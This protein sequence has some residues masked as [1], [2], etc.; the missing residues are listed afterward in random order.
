MQGLSQILASAPLP[1]LHRL[2]HF[3]MLRRSQEL[4][5]QLFQLCDGLLLGVVFWLAHA[6]RFWGTVYFDFIQSR[7]DPFDQFV[8]MLFIIIPFG[9]IMLE[10]Q[11][12]YQNTLARPVS[13]SVAQIIRAL[14]GLSLVIAGCVVFFR[15]SISSR[16]LPILFVFM[17]I[18]ALLVREWLTR[19]LLL[20][21][22]QNA[23]LRERV[24][25]A[26]TPRD[27]LDFEQSMEPEMRM[28][29]E[30]VGRVDIEKEPI[31]TLVQAL[32]DQSV[33]RVIF[34][35]EH[36]HL[37]KV[38][39]AVSACEIEGVEVW[40]IANFIRTQIAKPSFEHLHGKPMLVFR[41][42]PDVSWSLLCKAVIDRVGALALIALA[43]PVMLVC[44]ILVRMSSPGPV[45]YRQKR[46]GLHG[47]SF[48]ML[49]FR[50]MYVDAD[51]RLADLSAHNQMSG[52][53]FKM[54]NDPRITPIGHFLRRTSLD[55]FPQFFNVLAGDMSL[56]GPRP[57]P[58]YEVAKFEEAAQRRRLSVK[59]GLTCL[60]QISGRNELK[61]FNEWVRLD[62]QYI[63]N[64]S[65]WLDLKI[66]LK[67]IPVVLFGL[68]AK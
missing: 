51:A 12:F 41:T 63:D 57:L 62:L 21:R 60:W 34:A 32:H 4:N 27:M 46:A 3:P 22:A 65:I 16:A 66:L 26:G 7:I 43:S 50:S 11:G 29:T 55:E 35:A 56:V 36:T 28:T 40:L 37:A 10:L 30:I 68:G 13:S 44:A 8:W 49:K 18:P 42:T 61:D 58:T 2:S 33:S 31:A 25:L 9:P 24:L 6:L 38:E 17:A 39:A 64:W 5:Q 23:N 19:L 48:T 53:V 1:F 59:P 52:P 54:E 67:T 45:I 20:R 47:K 15:Y 14:L